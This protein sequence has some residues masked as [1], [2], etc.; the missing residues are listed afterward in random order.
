VKGVIMS[1]ENAL[2]DEINANLR[3]GG[4]LSQDEIA[5]QIGDIVVAENVLTR[6][7]RILEKDSVLITESRKIL[8]G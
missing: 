5:I 4:L 2:S 6:G 8:K 1:V 3:K 7:R